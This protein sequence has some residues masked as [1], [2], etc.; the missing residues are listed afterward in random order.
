MPTP[1][2]PDNVSYGSAWEADWR[3]CWHCGTRRPTTELTLGVQ[4]G[5]WFCNDRKWCEGQTT[6]GYGARP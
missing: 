5:Y 2:Q 1:S 4:D 3:K 6:Q